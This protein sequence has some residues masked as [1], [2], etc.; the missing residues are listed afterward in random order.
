MQKFTIKWSNDIMSRTKITRSKN[1][2]NVMRYNELNR[3]MKKNKNFRDEIL[4][5]IETVTFIFFFFFFCFETSTTIIS[6]VR[7]LRA[8]LTV[9]CVYN[10]YFLLY[11]QFH[12]KN[13]HAICKNSQSNISSV[14][15]KVD[16][17]YDFQ[18]SCVDDCATHCWNR[19][20]HNK[21]ENEKKCDA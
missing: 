4:C 18:N 14:F 1:A 6:N 13:K 21:S 20:C 5:V 8:Y 11:I 2:N 16:N 9:V 10:I 19:K 15:Q 17:V 3:E 7:S 12:N